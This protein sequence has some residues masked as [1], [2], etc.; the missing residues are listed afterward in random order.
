M[1][2]KTA[3]AMRTREIK[4]SEGGEYPDMKGDGG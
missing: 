2:E 1:Y 3:E 4:L